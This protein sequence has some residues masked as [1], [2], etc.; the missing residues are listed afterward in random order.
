MHGHPVDVVCIGETMALIAPDPP[1]PI[2]DAETFVLTHGGAESNVAA[3]LAALGAVVQWCGRVGDD[4]LGRRVLAELEAAGIGLSGARTDTEAPT[5][6]Y[7]KDP[8][9]GATRVWYYRVGS[10]GSRLDAD[11]V[12]RA[13][14]QRPR[15]VHLSGITPALSTS[16]AAAVAH[17][18]A[19][20]RELGVSVSFDVNYRPALWDSAAHAGTH[21]LPLA[22]DADVVFV[23]LDEAATLWG[24]L[25]ADDVRAVVGGRGTLVVKDGPR[26]AWSFA[27]GAA[28]SAPALPTQIV[29][30]VGAGDAFAAGWLCGL[31]R[32]VPPVA[33]LRLG[34]LVAAHALRSV[35]DHLTLTATP[36]ELLATAVG[37]LPG[38]SAAT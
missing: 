15:V 2:A 36:E 6:V 37:D 9:A 18:F 4:P 7:F 13:L 26:A 25:D 24:C 28:V 27:E 38:P 29:E 20:A 30:P 21:L 35:T 5:G 11:D 8:A 1:R 33:R 32:G 22:K 19:R 3:W 16:S 34:H 23:G 12:E 31:L 14:L 17:A 10:A